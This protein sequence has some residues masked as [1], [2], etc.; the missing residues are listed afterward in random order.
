AYAK[1]ETAMNELS[2][3]Q[4]HLHGASD[5]LPA[6]NAQANQAGHLRQGVSI[7][8]DREQTR[9]LLQQAPAIYRT[10]VN[11]LLLTA[12]ARTLSRWTDS[13]SA[14]IQLEGH[15][16]E[17]LFD[18]IDLTRTVGWFSSLFPVR[19]T[20][21]ADLGGSIKAIKQQL[22]DIPGKGLGYCL[23]R[24]L[25][26][27]AAQATLATLPQARVTFNYL[28]Q[29]D[30]SFAEDALFTPARESSGAA[31]SADAPLPNW[32]SV[33]GQVYGG[34]LKL[35]WTFSRECFELREIETL[36]NDFRAELL[37]LIDHCLSDGA[38]GVTPADFPLARL[39]Q[40]QLD[41]L[42]VPPAQIEDVYP[43]S[44]MQAGLL[45]HSLYESE[46]GA[47][48]NQLS[49]EARGLD[50]DRL[51]RAWQAVLGSHAILR[52]SFHFPEGFEAPVQLVHRHLP[53]PMTC[54]DWRG[55]A[56]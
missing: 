32:L 28:G 8:L 43:L 53:L 54:L 9:Q 38:G 14:L 4:S 22:R 45:F 41:A 5:S 11:D 18:D 36:A 13:E 31:Q 55:R 48:V 34:E 6:A 25:G 16:R 50:A 46:S 33:D 44:P 1:S 24:Y 10:Q 52:S 23:L 7:G 20:P 27:A 3:W 12:L 42:P 19:L 40:A 47:Y 39:S 26:D 15:G 30:Q 37:A 17:E 56:D 21:T 2:W 35:D 51:C 29:F 49:V